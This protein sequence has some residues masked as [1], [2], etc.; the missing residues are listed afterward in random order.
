MHYII[1]TDNV[2]ERGYL[3]VSRPAI[4]LGGTEELFIAHR[5]D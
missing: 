4:S 5:K 2:D 1:A 3:G